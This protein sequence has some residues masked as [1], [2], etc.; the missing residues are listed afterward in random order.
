MQ[1]IMKPIDCTTRHGKKGSIRPMRIR[2]DDQGEQ[3][4]INVDKIVS[5]EEL[6]TGKERKLVFRCRSVVGDVVRNYELMFDMV[7]LGWFL[8]RA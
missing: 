6:K 5:F 7:G 8:Y 2:Y 4:V 1:T 3:V